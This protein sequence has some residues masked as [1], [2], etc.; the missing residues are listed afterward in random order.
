VG[1]AAKLENQLRSTLKEYYPGFNATRCVIQFAL[2][3]FQTSDFHGSYKRLGVAASI[4]Q[5][6]GGT[7]ALK[8][9]QRAELTPQVKDV[10]ILIIEI[11]PINQHKVLARQKRN[12]SSLRSV[13][14]KL[15]LQ[16]PPKSLFRLSGFRCA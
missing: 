9:R 11:E 1:L 14:P 7:K 15:F 6:G 5:Q 8:R 16:F 10:L 3:F 13:R 2:K 12:L 4:E